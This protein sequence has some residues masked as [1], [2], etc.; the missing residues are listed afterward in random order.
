MCELS[1]FHP[2]G[3]LSF[4]RSRSATHLLQAVITRNNANTE[5]FFFNVC[6]Q[7]KERYNIKYL[8]HGEN[9][10]ICIKPLPN[11]Q[12]TNKIANFAPLR[13][14]SEAFSLHAVRNRLQPVADFFLFYLI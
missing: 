4:T 12:V 8:Y 6:K 1:A 7:V 11:L 9:N 13:V 10:F 3:L 14:S 2:D 5:V